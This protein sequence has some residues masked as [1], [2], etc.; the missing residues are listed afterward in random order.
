MAVLVEGYWCA[1]VAHSPEATGE[2]FLGGYQATAPHL[3][4]RWLRVQAMR[5]ADALDPLP[6]EGIFPSGCLRPVGE[7]Q[8]NPG[9]VFRAWVMDFRYQ[10]TQLHALAAGRQISV[11]SGDRDVCYSLSA[12]PIA[13]ESRL[14]LSGVI[15]AG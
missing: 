2:W 4:V 12:R 3:A 9:Q 1:V 14:T 15:G 11:S 13:V 5:L 6:G 7:G 8:P 10:G